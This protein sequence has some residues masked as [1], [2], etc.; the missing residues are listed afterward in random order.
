[1]LMLSRFRDTLFCAF[2]GKYSLN[3]S[4]SGTQQNVSFYVI[5]YFCVPLFVLLDYSYRSGAVT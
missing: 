5:Y 1:M 2:K 3:G 4:I